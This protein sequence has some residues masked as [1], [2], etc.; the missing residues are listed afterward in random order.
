MKRG[1]R[2][3]IEAEINRRT[4]QDLLTA[5]DKLIFRFK[6]DFSTMEFPL[7]DFLF[8]KRS[9]NSSGD[10]QEADKMNARRE[11]KDCLEKARDRDAALKGKF[12]KRVKD[13]EPIKKKINDLKNKIDPSDLLCSFLVASENVVEDELVRELKELWGSA[14]IIST[15][16]DG[17]KLAGNYGAFC[18]LLLNSGTLITKLIGR[19]HELYSAYRLAD[20]ILH[21]LSGLS[22]SIGIM[23]ILFYNR[24]ANLANMNLSSLVG[25]VLEKLEVSQYQ[26]KERSQEK[27]N[28]TASQVQ[29][30][31]RGEIIRELAH[32]TRKEAVLRR[33]AIK[34]P[35]VDEQRQLNELINRCSDIA[36]SIG[37]KK[38][39]IIGLLVFCGGLDSYLAY[40]NWKNFTDVSEETH[41]QERVYTSLTFVTFAL[42]LAA[43]FYLRHQT[44]KERLIRRE[45]DDD[46]C[47]DLLRIV[48]G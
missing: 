14:H 7:A 29:S 42:A 5:A 35:T 20:F 47:Q 25:K 11:L 38:Q 9:S 28:Q 46:L 39:F 2:E 33:K 40:A 48:S 19:D 41:D 44:K 24:Q 13:L 26:V 37:R 32:F 12:D 31:N 17:C 8:E 45:E 10:Q 34:E 30:L 27:R 22:A 18:A 21:I 4:C 3:R 16:G 23:S 1:G 43:Y 15:K 36:R 6:E